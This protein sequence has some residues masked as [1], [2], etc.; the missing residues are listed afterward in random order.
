MRSASR[1]QRVLF[2]ILIAFV[3]VFIVSCIARVAGG[4]FEV[5]DHPR[6]VW[7]L[8][9]GSFEVMWSDD[10]YPTDLVTQLVHSDFAKTPLWTPY[11]DSNPLGMSMFWV[12]TPLLY[13]IAVAYCVFVLVRFRDWR[14][15]K[16][17][18]HGG[19]RAC[20]YPLSAGMER[21][22]ECGTQRSS[23]ASGA[24]T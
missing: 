7:F 20:G 8:W 21:C 11:V 2:A 14:R 19:C 18:A 4:A 5:N 15:T 17:I 24:R 6:L 13:P 9:R 22:P 12:G 1:L 23:P 16:R 3:L 10:R